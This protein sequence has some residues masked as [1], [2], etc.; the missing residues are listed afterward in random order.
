M[1]WKEKK[2]VVFGAARQG[3]ATAA[4]MAKH[5]AHVVVTDARS[6]VPE[7]QSALADYAIEWQL[8]AQPL[9]LLD[10]AA[11]LS[12]SGGVPIE[13]PLVVEA[14]RRNIPVS[15]DS[16]LFMEAALCPV[17][18]ITGSAGKTTTTTLVGRMLQAMEGKGVRK[19]W[20]GGNIGNP[21]LANVDEMLPDDIAVM[22]LSSF[23]LEQMTR[24]PHIAAILN[25]A[26]NHLD[27]H[28]TMQAYVAAKARILDFQTADDIAILN[29]EDSRSWPLAERAVGRVWY[30]SR[31][32]L[33]PGQ[34]G[35]F[36]RRG[37]IWQRDS[38]GERMLIPVSAIE[39]RGEHNVMN[40]VAAC[41][42]AAAAGATPEAMRAGVSGFHGAPHRLEFVRT[43]NGVDYFNDS[44]ATAPQRAEASLRSF[45]QPV[46]L[47][48][49][50]RD[51]GLDWK[52]LSA[53]ATERARRVVLF[54]EAAGT[55]QPLFPGA[56]KASKFDDAV[57]QA[58]Q[59]AQP[60][61]AVLLAP[62]GTSFDEFKDFEARGERFRQLV[63]EL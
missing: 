9:S 21:L 43:V 27:R 44:I 47:L 22:E 55:L 12:L 16:Q 23:Q 26:P 35:T 13:D 17:I 24:A 59:L 5:G 56:I 8:G 53:L 62:G 28:P 48:L 18:G 11:L 14:V 15:N 36:L 30:F 61:D 58:A 31:N 39:L 54:G 46:V 19:V 49:G 25:L 52:S 63:N 60:G 57:K 4:Y 50:G 7:A 34:Q 20:V 33:A 10:G 42:I 3:I 41:A 29:R 38:R 1:D 2:I 51:K 45:D 37:Q 32:E 6:S 40:V